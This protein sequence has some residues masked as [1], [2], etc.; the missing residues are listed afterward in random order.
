MGLIYGRIRVMYV[1]QGD[2]NMATRKSYALDGFTISRLE[3]MEGEDGYMIRC[4]LYRNS[5]KLGMFFD[6]GDGSE[7]SFY[8]EKGVSQKAIEDYLATLPMIEPT[9]EG[10]PPIHWNIGILVDELIRRKELESRIR[11]AAKAGKSL[12]SICDSRTGAEY[13]MTCNSKMTDE[14]LEKELDSF[15]KTKGIMQ[16]SWKRY[17]SIEDI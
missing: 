17:D 6:R 10:F 9:E 3:M 1:I 7:Y 15:L 11:K 13:Q 16:F 14:V 4:S 2:K 5:K 8:P 12:V